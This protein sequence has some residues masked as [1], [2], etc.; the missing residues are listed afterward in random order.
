MSVSPAACLGLLVGRPLPA[1]VFV[2]VPRETSSFLHRAGGPGDFQLI[3]L[4]T[5]TH[6]L[7]HC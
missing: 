5:F 4:S 7:H 3:T 2:V 1:P 6:T